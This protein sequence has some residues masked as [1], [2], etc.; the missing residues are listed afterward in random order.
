MFRTGLSFDMRSAQFG[1]PQAQLYP[2][3]LEMIE[4]A[5]THGIE[6][7]IISE[8]HASEDGYIPGPALLAAA[9]GARTRHIAITL[10]AIVLPLHDPVKVAE[11]IAVTDLICGGRLHTV[12]AAGYAHHEFKA[13]RKSLADRGRAMDRGLEIIIRA[14]AGERFQDGEREV[15]V[16]PLPLS[17]R[18][19][20]YVGGGVAAAARRA[21]RFGTGFWPMSADLIPVYEDACRQ[22]GREPGS[23]IGMSVGIHVTEDVD[24]GWRDVGPYVLHQARAYAAI[25]AATSESH[26]PLHGLNSL[27]DVR[28]SGIIQVL[29]PDQCVELARTRSLALV[30]LTAGL[31]PQ[32]GWKSLELFVTRALPRIKAMGSG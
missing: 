12:L 1:T 6:N 23:V 11:Q 21:A 9:A 19:R 3:A 30:P 26:S 16:R 8:H 18:A 22:L 28:A 24:Q 2:A 4:Y 13:F 31:A 17:A 15:F 7:V 27:E 20:L 32:V 29:T 10:G 5:D 14:L 25:S